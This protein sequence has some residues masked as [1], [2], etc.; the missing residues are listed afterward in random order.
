MKQRD[1]LHVKF[2]IICALVLVHFPNYKF[3]LRVIRILHLTEYR[4]VSGVA[5]PLVILDKVKVDWLASGHFRKL[6]FF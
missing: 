5:G 2:E 3:C 6:L 1:L 4:T